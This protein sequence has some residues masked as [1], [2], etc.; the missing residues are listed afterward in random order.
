MVHDLFQD[1]KSATDINLVVAFEILK[2]SELTVVHN[3]LGIKR[4]RDELNILRRRKVNKTFCVLKLTFKKF[5]HLAPNW[6][7]STKIYI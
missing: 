3:K 2:P 7:S 5:T 1:K 4:E 6:S